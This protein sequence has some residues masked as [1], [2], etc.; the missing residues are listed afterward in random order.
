[1]G[2]LVRDLLRFWPNQPGQKSSKSF[3][4]TIIIGVAPKHLAIKQ[5]YYFSS[6]SSVS[7]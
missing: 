5:L 4:F 2:G 7:K 1:M 3:K 6:G